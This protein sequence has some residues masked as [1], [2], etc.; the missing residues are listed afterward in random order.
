[1]LAESDPS[2]DAGIHCADEQQTSSD[3]ETSTSD[4]RSMMDDGDDN[5]QEEMDIT[6]DAVK[7][8]MFKERGNEQFKKGNFDEAIDSYTVAIQADVSNP[9]L[10]GN[11]AM[12]LLKKADSMMVNKRKDDPIP[13][14]V[15]DFY[16]AADQDCSQALRLDKDFVKAYFRRGMA[17]KALGM[18]SEALFDFEMVRKLEPENAIAEKTA[19]M[20]KTE[21]WAKGKVQKRFFTEFK[22]VPVT[23]SV[24]NDNW[25]GEMKRIRIEE[26]NINDKPK[27]QREP[28]KSAEEK[29][30]VTIPIEIPPPPT[31]SYQ[32][33]RDWRQLERH[34]IERTDYLMAID[35]RRIK[36]VFK[37]ALEV[38]VFSDIIAL[39]Y[40][41]VFENSERQENVLPKAVSLL[42]ALSHVGR[43]DTL[44]MFLEQ[45]ESR[46]IDQM[47]KG[48]MTIRKLW[49]LE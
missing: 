11:R 18:L 29:M 5:D 14:N 34:P 2:I 7:S 10:Y 42:E 27:G 26:L 36:E 25:K 19:Q 40:N 30:E 49:K 43:F 17:R 22:S 38:D 32:F 3:S 39:L 16:Q 6:H 41:A 15:A 28:P 23:A 48:E 47:L 45:E 46:K 31:T 8:N 33:Y 37:D 24:K 13:K 9:V 20:L 44:V 12:A 4:D 35:S 1:M 21:L